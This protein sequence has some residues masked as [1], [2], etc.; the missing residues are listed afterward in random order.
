MTIFDIDPDATDESRREV[1]RRLKDEGPVTLERRHKRKDGSMFP[2]EVNLR[3][4]NLDREYTVAVSR[5]VTSRKLAEG[6]LREFER[7]V[8]N[9]EEMIVVV[10]RDY[11]YVIVNRSFLARRGCSAE[12]IVGR[13]ASEVLGREVF[14]NTVKEKLDE[15]FSGKVVTYEI[16]YE[17]PQ[18]GRRD[19]SITYV[20]V[21]GAEGI[22][23][24]A[25]VI[26]DI[27]IQKGAEEAIKLSEA[28]ERARANELQTVFDA[29]PV[30]VYISHDRD[31]R[32]VTGNRAAYRQLRMSEG[33]NFSKS[34][35]PGE[36][37]KFRLLHEGVEVSPEMLPMQQA[38][39]KGEEIYESAHT[40]VFEDGTERQTLVNAVPLF[41]EY[42]NPRGAVGSSIDLTDLKNAENALRES[43]QRFR[44][45]YER[46]PIGITLLDSQTGQFLQVNQKFCEITGRTEKDLLARDALSITHPDD[47]AKGGDTLQQLIDGKLTSYEIDKRYVRPDQSVR[48]VRDFGCAD[49]EARRYAALAYGFS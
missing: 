32:T 34:A 11:R 39:L 47:R 49:V 20:P 36:A 38:A 40:I 24:V 8:E 35:P 17:Y 13:Q 14:E 5:D 45:L 33:A 18:L 26:R 19:L 31:C 44:S 2:V 25:C 46:S 27:T 22:D 10:D 37:P 42:A 1:M 41:D 3:R 29:V 12:S 16:E 48:W 21:M 30:P 6:R 7:V 9:L 28:R 15:C 43:E 23:R 4:V